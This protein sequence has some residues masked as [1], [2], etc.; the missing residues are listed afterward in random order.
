MT[1]QEDPQNESSSPRSL[2]RKTQH[3]VTPTLSLIASHLGFVNVIS[4]FFN[5]APQHPPQSNH[6]LSVYII[7][8]YVCC[9]CSGHA[10]AL[11]Q[12]SVLFLVVVPFSFFHFYSSTGF[13]KQI[14]L[15]LS[16]F[17]SPSLSL[18]LTLSNHD[19]S[20]PLPVLLCPRVWTS[21]ENGRVSEW[22]LGPPVEGTVLQYSCL[23][24]FIL[25]GRNS[26]HCNK[27]GKWDSRKPVCHCEYRYCSKIVLG[28]N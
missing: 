12:D 7:Y 3:S 17:F 27:L 18:T 26:T 20:L 28:S 24:G 1:W 4:N 8:M 5:R 14:S 15:S 10:K 21:L 13:K 9:L 11:L 6:S 22:P 2:F 16:L 19:L 25:I 23:P